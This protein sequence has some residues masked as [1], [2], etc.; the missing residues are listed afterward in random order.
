MGVFFARPWP[1]ARLW[2]ALGVAFCVAG[3]ASAV[4]C[5]NVIIGT[6]TVRTVPLRFYGSPADAAVIIDDQRVGSLA[7]VS[8][9]GVRVYAG[10][11]R[12]SVEAPG[13]L[14]FDEI[15]EAKDAVVAVQVTLVP[16]PD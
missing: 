13:F 10:R 5:T 15:V 8:A 16:I 2:G 9:R 14:P 1:A 4:G 11:H 12:I 6:P 3:G 7:L